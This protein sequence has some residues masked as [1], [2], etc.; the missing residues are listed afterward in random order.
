MSNQDLNESNNSL[1]LSIKEALNTIKSDTKKQVTAPGRVAISPRPVGRAYSSPSTPKSR[2]VRGFAANAD[3]KVRVSLLAPS[4]S[5][6]NV[7]RYNKNKV[8]GE[9]D[10][11]LETEKLVQ[12]EVMSVKVNLKKNDVR[13]PMETR[14][15][16][17]Y[18]ADFTGRTRPVEA[19]KG[20]NIKEEPKNTVKEK[21]QEFN[22]AALV[23]SV[24]NHRDFI[25]KFNRNSFS[26][27]FVLGAIFKAW[28][29]QVKKEKTGGE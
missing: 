21:P 10:E 8:A 26:Q 18:P 15:T 17:R 14:T 5:Y 2:N 16:L 1:D 22:N 23:S 9:L 27:N 12:R 13:R 19:G 20:R 6:K 11:F 7:H 3:S 29:M 25:V 24:K 4:Q 28:S